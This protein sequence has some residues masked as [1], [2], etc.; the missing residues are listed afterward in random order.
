MSLLNEL[1]KINLSAE[2]INYLCE[3]ITSKKHIWEIQFMHL[4]VLLLN[5]SA[6]T[7]D[8]KHFYLENLRKCRKLALKLFLIRGFSAYASES[9]LNP[10]MDRFNK[11]FEKNHDYIEYSYILSA[12]GLPYLVDLYGYGCFARA[13]EKAND[14]YQ[15][16]DPL[17]RGYFTLN[18]NLELI[19][20]VSVED[21]HNRSQMFLKKHKHNE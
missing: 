12:A 1:N 8:L 16:I 7:F 9:E 15:K 10:I 5:P 18:S 14:E 11:C 13:L 6:N 19:N 3:M 20:L 2:L 21:T 4:R 17:L